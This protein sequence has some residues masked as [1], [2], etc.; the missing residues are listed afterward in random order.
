MGNLSQHFNREEFAC[1]H[2]GEPVVINS[3][4]RC[5]THNRNVG[6]AARS[7]HVQGTAGDV[8][9]VNVAPSRVHAYLIK[10]YPN[11]YGIGKYNTFTHID[12]RPTPARWTG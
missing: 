3:G 8:K 1:N 4:Y 2:C 7:T 12:M 11:K 6:G 9:V 10:R 5:P